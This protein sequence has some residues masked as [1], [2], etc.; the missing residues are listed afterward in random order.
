MRKLLM[1]RVY[2]SDWR[3][4]EHEQDKVEVKVETLQQTDEDVQTRLETPINASV[5]D[6]D[7][8]ADTPETH[9]QCAD[10]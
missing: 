6:P 1:I 7:V 3:Q 5:R 4:W 9:L 2:R 10:I 8:K